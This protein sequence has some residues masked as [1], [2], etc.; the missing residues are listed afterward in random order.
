MRLG[1]PADRDI[2]SVERPSVGRE[3]AEREILSIG[4]RVRGEGV[5]RWVPEGISTH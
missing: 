2:E 3:A 1:G 4:D 5:V